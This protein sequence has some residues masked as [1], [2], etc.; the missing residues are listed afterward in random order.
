MG[1]VIGVA[2]GE[3]GVGLVGVVWGLELVGEG[4]EGY[5][6]LEGGEEGGVGIWDCVE[7]SDGIEDKASASEL[8]DM[9]DLVVGETRSAKCVDVV[10][11]DVKGVLGEGENG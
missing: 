2:G 9:G 6:G 1:V 7:V 5:V 4:S 3:V 11:I 10:G 8:H